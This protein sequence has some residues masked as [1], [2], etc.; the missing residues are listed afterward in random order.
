[1]CLFVYECVCVKNEICD[2]RLLTL[3]HYFLLLMYVVSIALCKLLFVCVI[4]DLLS[5]MFILYIY[6]KCMY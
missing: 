2:C 4:H 6:C 5:G 1:M 3:Y